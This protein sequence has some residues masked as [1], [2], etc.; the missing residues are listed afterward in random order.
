ML[1]FFT[2]ISYNRLID[3]PG[4]PIP[5]NIHKKTSGPPPEYLQ[6][7]SEAWSNNIIK[8]IESQYES[9][10]LEESKVKRNPRKVDNQTHCCLY[11]FDPQVVTNNS[12]LTSVDQITLA[13]LSE[14]VNVIPC[15]AKSDLLSVRQLA[16]VKKLIMDDIKKYD[17]G[18]QMFENSCMDSD[19]DD[20]S[21]QNVNDPAVDMISNL[22]SITDHYPFALFN[23]EDGLVHDGEK[24]LGR[25][26][27]WV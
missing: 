25:E 7:L 18:I 10:L 22:N 13:R 3:T 16:N 9:T 27:A 17:I 2:S 19:D 4:L 23:A 12:G 5:V 26:F 1:N 15:I 11:F 8:C 20:E 6:K 14:K 21:L 24:I